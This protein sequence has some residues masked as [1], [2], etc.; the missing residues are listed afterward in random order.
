MLKYIM[1]LFGSFVI[2]LS[3]ILIKDYRYSPELVHNFMSF[4]YTIVS[5]NPP[6]L[7]TTPPLEKE[8]IGYFIGTGTIVDTYSF[9]KYIF[10]NNLGEQ[11]ILNTDKNYQIGDNLRLA[12]YAKDVNLF[13]DRSSLSGFWNRSFDYDKRLIMKGYRG[14]IYEG[15]SIL[16]NDGL[17]LQ[18]LSTTLGLRKG[19]VPEGQVKQKVGFI[20]NMKRSL[21]SKIVS[22]YGEG[23]NAGL[24]LGMLIG[25]KSQIPKSDYQQFI[26]SGLV[27][28]IAV[29]GGN[30]I[31][32]TIFLSFILFFLP[33]YFRNFVILGSIILYSLVCGMDSS[34]MRAVLFG[35]LGMMALFVGREVNLW[36]SVYLAFILMLIIN[37]YFLLYDL[38]FLLSFGAIIGIRIFTSNKQK[39]E[40]KKQ[41]KDKKSHISNLTFQ[42][43]N[44]YIKPSLGAN[45]GILPVIIFF[46]GKINLVGFIANLFVLPIVPFVMIYGF[47]SI[48]IYSL[49]PRNGFIYIQNILINYI[50]KVSQIGSDYGI[51]L[52]V[53]DYKIKYLILI[54]FVIGLIIYIVKNKIIVCDNSYIKNSP[55]ISIKHN[56]KKS[57]Y[58][59][60]N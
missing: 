31:M 19:Q 27:H 51:Y 22:T 4:N 49:L 48:F 50:Y 35:G 18:T 7:R 32:L 20:A 55:N 21:Q 40:S 29:S 12:G 9:G 46:M 11:Y 53:D 52:L 54:L 41:I 15:N 30:I 8:D 28:L 10:E 33:F 3:A 6:V 16:L 60:K 58:L 34:V 2:A 59:T 17:R 45:I 5:K 26:D 44:G 42:I 39:S 14:N 43:Y 24:I 56:R 38:G 13:A 57:N 1:I 37:P 47:I 25:D 23:R 36:R